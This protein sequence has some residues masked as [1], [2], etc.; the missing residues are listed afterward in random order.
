MT[1]AVELNRDGLET[2]VECPNVGKC[3]APGGIHIAHAAVGRVL[4]VVSEGIARIAR[5]GVAPPA[6]LRVGNDVVRRNGPV[7]VV[8]VGKG[9]SNAVGC[10]AVRGNAAHGIVG[11]GFGARG[12]CHSGAA[13]DTVGDG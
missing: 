6:A 10:T 11:P 9:F 4:E 2:V 3:V 1:G 7:E 5:T 8:G 13:P 12:V